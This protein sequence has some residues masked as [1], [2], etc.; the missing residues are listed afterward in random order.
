MTNSSSL[1]KAGLLTALCAAAVAAG[2]VLD[3]LDLGG[4]GPRALLGVLALAAVAAAAVH[5]RRVGA[6]VERL[7]AVN[8]S[9]AAGDFEARVTGIR[10]GGGLGA[11]MHATNDAIDRTDAFVREATASMH[12]VSEH[13]YFRRIM[14]RG[15]NGGFLHASRTINAATESIARKVTGF[16]GVT[17]RFEGE[18]QSVCTG[19]AETAHRLEVSARLMETDA[20]HA[21]GKAS[22][23]AA[24]AAQTGGNVGS[25]AEATEE[26]SASISD[27]ARQIAEVAR[28]AETAAG[29][30]ERS[31]ALVGTLSGAARTVGDVVTLIN[32]IATQTNLLALNATIEAARAGE[33][34]KG[35]A[36]VAQEVKRLADQTAMATG[37]IAGQIAGIQSSTDE[38]VGAIVGIGR[39]IQ[40]INRIAAGISAGIEQQG[41]AVREI[42]ANMEQ[43]AVGTRA[44]SDDIQQVTDAACRTS[45]TA[46]E[47]F[48][49]SER[50]AAEADRLTREVQHFLEEMHRV[51]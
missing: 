48:A 22:S 24:S 39:T 41:S 8:R 7:A 38:A 18:I 36:V 35:F 37:E 46:H 4:A 33:A 17:V 6:V 49:A 21:T 23:V 9:I 51:A 29:E 19:V 14:L 20:T 2:I 42:V 12:A 10:E 50:M 32:D 1:S 25:V 45:G 15:M 16:A 44:V 3:A 5:L 30:A 31:N 43:A 40:S 47:V 11:L 27:I 26:L 13:K 28:V 34:G